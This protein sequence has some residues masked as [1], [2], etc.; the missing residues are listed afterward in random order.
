MQ[1]SKLIERIAELLELKKLPLLDDIHDESAEDIRI[2]LTPKSRVVE[3]EIL[4]EQLFRA[5]DLEA[6]IPL[7]MNGAGQGACPAS[8][9]S[10]K[11]VL[12]A[13]AAHRREVL[14]RRSDFPPGERSGR[15]WKCWKAIWPSSSTSTR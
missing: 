5:S 3:P 4:M 12:A 2:V 11:E 1:K 15:G 7:N 6:R 10:L 13:F 14:E 9:M 8:V